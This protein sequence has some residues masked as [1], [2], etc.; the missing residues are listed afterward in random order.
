MKKSFSAFNFV[1]GT[2]FGVVL[3]L[4]LAAVQNP[5][6]TAPN[7]SVTQPLQPAAPEP[8]GFGAL[9][10]FTYPNGGTGI[11]DPASGVLYIYDNDLNRCYLT[12]KVGTLGQPLLQRW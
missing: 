12:R 2:L 6:G 10:F 5:K 11:F 9:K 7:A 3:A 8:S 4:C 1:S